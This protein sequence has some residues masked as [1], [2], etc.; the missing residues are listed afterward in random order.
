M[1]CVTTSKEDF[2]TLQ[3][4]NF[5]SPALDVASNYTNIID[6]LMKPQALSYLIVIAACNLRLWP[7]LAS[8]FRT[9]KPICAT[10]SFI[11]P[12]DT[13]LNNKRP[14][15][16]AGNSPRKSMADFDLVCQRLALNTSCY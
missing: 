15:K 4:Q 9:G 1:I 8:P 3:F 2:R 13:S 14:Y 12:S 16:L 11:V 6:M 5:G 7:T 10:A